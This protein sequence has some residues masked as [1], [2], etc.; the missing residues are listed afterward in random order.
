MISTASAAQIEYIEKYN[1]FSYFTIE[2]RKYH[3]HYWFYFCVPY[4]K[5]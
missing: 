3:V 5:K 4:F 2:I 1:I